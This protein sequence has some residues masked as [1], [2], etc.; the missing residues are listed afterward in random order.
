MGRP[1]VL[2]CVTA[3]MGNPIIT[4]ASR[5]ASV[6]ARNYHGRTL[7]C[8]ASNIVCRSFIQAH[9][10]R[11]VWAETILQRRQMFRQNSAIL[12]LELC[13]LT[14]SKRG[15]DEAGNKGCHARQEV[16]Q[17]INLNYWHC[18]AV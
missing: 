12:T 3:Y 18:T 1:R 13:L 8:H 5:Q 4:C 7:G 17:A 10:A 14:V 15:L 11:I 6:C 2:E 9:E 16:A